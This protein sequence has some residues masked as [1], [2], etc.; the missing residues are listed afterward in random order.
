MIRQIIKNNNQ[1]IVLISQ[2][3]ALIICKMVIKEMLTLIMEG[4]VMQI[5]KI[6][7]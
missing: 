1:E 6:I 2:E 5:I 7:E 4:M 3:P